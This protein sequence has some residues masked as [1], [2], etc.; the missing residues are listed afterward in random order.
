[1]PTLANPEIIDIRRF[2]AGDFR[3][4]LDAE[5][6]A[7]GD[8]L[9]WDYVSASQLVF[10][11]LEEKRLSGYALLNGRE[12][13]GYGFF[14]YE[15]EKA[16]IGDLFVMPGG[17]AKARALVLLERVLETLLATPGIGRVEA[18]LPHFHLE[19]LDPCF[20]AHGFESYL[21]RFMAAPLAGW[22]RP[23]DSSGSGFHGAT[24][25][26]AM[27]E[28]R[29]SADFLIEPWDRRHDHQVAQLIYHTYHHHVDGFI[30][31]Q[32]M[33][34]EG[35]TRLMETIT[36]LGGCGEYLADESLVAIHRPTR[37]V[38]A[39][40]ALTAVRPRRTAHIPQVAVAREF[41]GMG[42][43]TALMKRAFARLAVKGFKEVSLTVTDLNAGAVRLYEHLGFTT[44]QTFGAFVW[45]SRE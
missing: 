3:L 19:D 4:L 8:A 35:A 44:F 25:P 7:W 15:G 40:L 20:R 36:H 31:D 5:S 17:D 1:M 9:R 13:D 26:L 39:L 11:C 22:D 45:N 38:A 6:K 41:Q 30:N 18:Q 27:R 2:K 23:S 12:I 28:A 33:S 32:Y 21:R 24:N 29:V 37:R 16:L 14:F 42:L 34:T 43:G 10:T